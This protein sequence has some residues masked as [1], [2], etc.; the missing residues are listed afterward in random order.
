MRLLYAS[1]HNVKSSFY[2]NFK[3]RPWWNTVLG[4]NTPLTDFVDMHVQRKRS[5]I[6]PFFVAGLVAFCNIFPNKWVSQ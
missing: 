5:K 6:M 4:I 3:V 2:L 1:R